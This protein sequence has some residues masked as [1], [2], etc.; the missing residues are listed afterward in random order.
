MD[1]LPKPGREP[2]QRQYDLSQIFDPV[3]LWEDPE[4]C[5]DWPLM[6]ENSRHMNPTFSRQDAEN[7]LVRLR[8]ML[9]KQTEDLPAPTKSEAAGAR[10]RYFTEGVAPSWRWNELG[11]G[12]LRPARRDSD[13]AE[14]L[15]EAVHLRGHLRKLDARIAS[16][17]RANADSE[18]RKLEVQVSNY[19]DNVDQLKAELASLANAEARHRDRLEDEKAFHRC[20]DIRRSLQVDRA[21]AQI[22]AGKL[23]VALPPE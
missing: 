17:E 5:P 14:L 7:R 2:A 10:A 3:E 4:D 13:V 21:S 8:Y 20:Y 16:A 19:V 6:D 15:V 11:F 18:R 12:R 23:G 22:A 1:A 9:N